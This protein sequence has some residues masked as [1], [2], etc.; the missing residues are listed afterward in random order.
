MKQ[1]V[2]NAIF[3]YKILCI[4]SCYLSRLACGRFHVVLKICN[5]LITAL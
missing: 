3:V 2:L 4:F 1:I 5:I